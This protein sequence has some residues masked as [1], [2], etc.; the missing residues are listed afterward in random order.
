M[1]RKIFV[2]III[3]I[4]NFIPG[5][6]LDDD[7]EISD[8]YNF[9]VMASDGSFTGYYSVDGG[10]FHFFTITDHVPDNENFYSYEKNLDSPDSVLIY[11]TGTDDTAT[12]ISIYIYQNDELVDSVTVS[13]TTDSNGNPLKVVASISYTFTDSSK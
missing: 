6:V 13:Q 3:W 4:L 1:S 7:E 2:I 12:S 8:A 9:K 5:C 10:A 11:A